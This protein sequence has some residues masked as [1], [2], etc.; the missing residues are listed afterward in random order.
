MAAA[1]TRARLHPSTLGALTASVR[2]P[3]FD[4]SALRCGIVHLGIGAF[5]RAHLAAAT[6]DA[7]DAGAGPDWGICGVSLRQADTRDALA[8]Q[9]GLYALALRDAHSEHLRVI[10]C[11]RE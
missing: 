2:I 11:V 8:P 6:D 4:R 7:L 5:M 1:P 10:G 3:S 9:D